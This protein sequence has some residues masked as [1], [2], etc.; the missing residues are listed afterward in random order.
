MENPVTDDMRMQTD[1][2]P[3]G[4]EGDLLKQC[5]CQSKVVVVQGKGSNL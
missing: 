1:N 4:L 3:E 5:E 2:Q